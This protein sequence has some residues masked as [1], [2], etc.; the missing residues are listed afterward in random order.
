MITPRHVAVIPVKEIS[1]RVQNKNFRLFADG[2]TLLEFKLKHLLDSKIFDEIY[3]SSDSK[4]AEEIAGNHGVRFLERDNY[5]CNNT[6][7]WSDVIHHVIDS[8]PESDATHVSWC[9]T[10]SP[11]FNRYG[12]CYNKYLSLLVDEGKEYDGLVAVKSLN[13]F[14]VNEKSRPVNYNWGIWHDYSQYLDPLYSVNGALFLMT[15]GTYLKNR[16]VM[17]KRPYLFKCHEWES[18]DLDN[19]FDFKLAQIIYENLNSLI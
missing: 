14:I 5:F 10:T 8:I 16:Y 9:H 4:K 7:S 15:K 6:T 2:R 3:I 1:E 18:I 12:E 11:L 17:S 19:E 13:E